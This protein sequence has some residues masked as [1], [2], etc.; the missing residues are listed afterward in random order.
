[1]ARPGPF[2]IREAEAT[3]AT[4]IAALLG[5]LG[6]PV[7]AD[8]I[9]QRLKALSAGRRT[10]ALVAA[11]GGTAIGLATAHVFASIH[12][13]EPVCWVTT[14]VVASTAQRRGAGEALLAALESW[15]MASG[16]VRISVLTG[17]QRDG[18]HAFYEHFGYDHSGRRYTKVLRA[19]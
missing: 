1:M 17:I 8:A 3:D 15:A 7:T 18:A 11:E 19:R 14:L 9:P 2:S 13:A 16:C 6:Y 10:I 5:E 4:P 12:A